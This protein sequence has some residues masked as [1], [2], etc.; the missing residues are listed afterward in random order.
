MRIVISDNV[1]V[2]SYKVSIEEPT[3]KM[4]VADVELNS[5]EK[6][7][8]VN[9]TYPKNGFVPTS[10]KAVI[11][12]EAKD[13]SSWQFFTGN[14]AVFESKVI[15]DNK[16]P[17]VEVISNSAY[18]AKGGS[19]LVVFEA[20]DENLEKAYI[21]TNDDKI[22]EAQPFGKK[23]FF[24]SLIAWNI[25][26][27][28]FSA[29]VIAIDKANNKS[30]MPIMMGAKHI[31]YKDSNLVLKDDFLDGKVLELASSMPNLNKAQKVDRF[32][33][34]NGQLRAQNEQLVQKIT[35]RVGNDMLNSYFT[36]P[37]VPIGKAAVVGTYGDHRNFFY[38]GVKVSES[39]HMGIDF[40]STKEA[41]ILAPNDGVVI[42]AGPN[43]IFGNMMVL[44]HNLGFFTIYGHCSSFIAKEGEQVARGQVIAK[45]GSTGLALGDHLHFG[46]IVQ[47]VEVRPVEWLDS[48]WIDTNIIKVMESAK[49]TIGT[50]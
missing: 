26:S 6:V 5:T 36:Q 35:S 24:V 31:A 29:E 23:G 34:V 1:G 41:D 46:T 48:K 10:D 32:I 8:D 42:Y 38:G 33:Y 20:Q 37:F 50:R 21:K 27:P 3:R 12:I 13:S 47:G 17:V 11:R 7:I 40:A 4:V 44:Y 49:K 19:A 2:K 22:F 14:K 28:E 25:K 18:I 15:A 43:G 30:R 45:T 9:V 39:Y 16:P